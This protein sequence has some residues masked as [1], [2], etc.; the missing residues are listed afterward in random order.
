MRIELDAERRSVLPESW[1]RAFDWTEQKLGGRVRAWEPQPRWRPACFFELEREG[2]ILPLYWRGSRGEW[3]R[4]AKPLAREMHVI[5]VFERNGISVPHPYGL[6]ESPPGLLLGRLPGR[7][8]LA[9]AT[10]DAH[11]SKTLDEYLR[12][13]ARIHEIPIE[14]FEA[15]GFRRPETSF[16]IN[17][18]NLP[19]K[20]IPP[21]PSA[22]KR[23]P[24]KS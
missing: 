10:D 23:K 19:P 7:F 5:E 14:E 8:N 13:L 18:A 1:Q 11:H 3:H 12:Q 20:P 2:E 22:S 24:K 4:D 21:A 16:T 6:C 15:I 17:D 9:T